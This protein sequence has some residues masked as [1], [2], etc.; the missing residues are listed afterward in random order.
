[1]RAKYEILCA[2][3]YATWDTPFVSPSHFLVDGSLGE[4]SEWHFT[5]EA[6][7]G[8]SELLHSVDLCQTRT[9]EHLALLGYTLAQICTTVTVTLNSCRS[10]KGCVLASFLS[11]PH[12]F[13]PS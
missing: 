6:R 3:E 2:K 11:S 12:P 10:G 5:A 7:W 8:R 1:M 9:S 4:D 13:L